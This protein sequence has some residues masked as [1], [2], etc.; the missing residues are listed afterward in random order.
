MRYRLRA[1]MILMAIGPP[2]LAG[3]WY[4]A[5]D[6]PSQERDILVQ[7]LLLGLIGAAAFALFWC[8]GLR[9]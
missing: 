5:F 7:L 2:L 9:R 6:L 1:L 8:V 3:A 4:F